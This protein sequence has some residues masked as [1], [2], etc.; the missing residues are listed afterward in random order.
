MTAIIVGAN[1]TDLNANYKDAFNGHRAEHGCN[2]HTCRDLLAMGEDVRQWHLAHADHIRIRAPRLDAD[3]AP[4]PRVERTPLHERLAHA[5]DDGTIT[6]TGPCGETKPANKFPTVKGGIGRE[7]R[8]R[9]CRDNKGG[10][11]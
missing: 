3:G 8:C 9:A 11:G 5:N 1:V 10:T 2:P 6:C 4:L 7:S